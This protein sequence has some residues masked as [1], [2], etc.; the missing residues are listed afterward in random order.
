[1]FYFLEKT[2]YLF[3]EAAKGWWWEEEEGRNELEYW[4]CRYDYGECTESLYEHDGQ[5]LVSTV[6]SSGVA[7]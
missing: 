3:L 7:S 2:M 6:L 1:M 4:W 5:Y